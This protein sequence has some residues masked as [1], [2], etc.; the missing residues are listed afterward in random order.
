MWASYKAKKA[1][2]LE[3]YSTPYQVHGAKNLLAALF[4]QLDVPGIILLIAVFGCILTV[5]TCPLINCTSANRDSRS[6]SRVAINHNGTQ[7]K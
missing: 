6:Q 1:G 3:S 7:L 4:W 2:A 5:G